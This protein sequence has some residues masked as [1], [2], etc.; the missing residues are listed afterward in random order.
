MRTIEAFLSIL[1][2]FSALALAT[3]ISPAT[4]LDN[5]NTLATIGMQ[6][7][8][9]MDT[10]GRL[11]RLINEGNWT[12]LA[13]ALDTLLPVGLSYNLSVYDEELQPVNNVSISNGIIPDRNV[14][15]VQYPCVSPRSQGNC[16]LLRLQLATAR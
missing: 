10:D 11:G 7:L 14:I 2:L 9:S 12:I 16:Y 15:S 4:N 3:L 13:N 8:V 1:L 6:A 5:D